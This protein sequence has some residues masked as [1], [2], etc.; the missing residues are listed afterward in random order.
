M[1]I[2][3]RRLRVSFITA[4]YLAQIA[5]VWATTTHAACPPTGETTESLQA[6]KQ[7][8]WTRPEDDG[9]RQELAVALLDCLADP[10][11]LL[12]DEI[13]YEALSTWMRGSKLTAQTMQT[14]RTRLLTVLRAPSDPAGFR[15]PFAALVLAEVARVDR[16]H[17]TLSDDERAEL[18]ATGTRWLAEFRDY[19]AYD[20]TQG[21]RHGVA[22]GADLMLQLSLNEK[23]LRA[24]ADAILAAIAVQVVPPGV[25]AYQHGESDRLAAPVYYLAKSPLLSEADWTHWFD[26]LVAR[27]QREPVSPMTLAEKHNLSLFLNTLYVAVQEADSTEVKARLLPGLRA[28]LREVE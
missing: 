18:V 2:V 7:S 15:Q 17:G 23:L 22:H 21:W 14:L 12:R 25:V 11:P 26:A 1:L 4:C 6:L 19:R 13:A 3:P 24:Q 10:D 20:P 9:A 8:N 27:R 16:L 28:A 5:L